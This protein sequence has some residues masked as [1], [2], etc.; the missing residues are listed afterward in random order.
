MKRL[1]AFVL[2]LSLASPAWAGFQEGLLAYARRDYATAQK[3]WQLPAEHGLAAAQYNLG[4]LYATGRGVAKDIATALRWYRKAADQG[5]V[6]AQY[7]LGNMYA[8]GQG[9]PM[10]IA[11]ALSWYRKAADQGLAKA[12]YNL[13]VL[14][15]NGQGVPQDYVQAHLWFAL[16]AAQGDK[17]ALANRDLVINAMTA[18]EIAEAQRLAH[19]WLDRF[20]R[21]N[22]K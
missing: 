1:T 16:A 11:Q 21:R 4:T 15:G 12:Q 7:T 19:E 18:A 10:S 8:T 6:S 5:L 17:D 13:G 3:E 14:Y 20:R 22:G 9:V 2:C